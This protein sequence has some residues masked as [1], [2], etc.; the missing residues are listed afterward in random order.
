MNN[1]IITIATDT[2]K[3]IT[4]GYNPNFYESEAKQFE[5]VVKD[6]ENIKKNL[7]D[8]KLFICAA[9]WNDDLKKSNGRLYQTIDELINEFK[10][11]E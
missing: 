9:F 10:S 2:N 7:A 5:D 4:S 1:I 8:E 6:L 3:I 11:K